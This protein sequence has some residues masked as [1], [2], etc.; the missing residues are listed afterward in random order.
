MSTQ[1]KVRGS[2]SPDRLEEVIQPYATVNGINPVNSHM[3]QGEMQ[4]AYLEVM[5]DE[6]KDTLLQ[7]YAGAEVD[8][9]IHR[10]N[11]EQKRHAEFQVHVIGGTAEEQKEIKADIE[12]WLNSDYEP[13]KEVVAMALKQITDRYPIHVEA[14]DAGEMFEIFCEHPR[15]E[16]VVVADIGTQVEDPMGVRGYDVYLTVEQA[17]ELVDVLER[18]SRNPK[19]AE[20][21]RGKCSEWRD[22]VTFLIDAEPGQE[23]EHGGEPPKDPHE[24]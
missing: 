17:C 6:I 13:N 11:P 5:D 20:G 14:T 2:V 24:R 1:I 21:D 18:Y 8:V 16:P 9:D 10:G 23:N 7:H 19:I 4:V 22:K 3:I 12:G 15:F